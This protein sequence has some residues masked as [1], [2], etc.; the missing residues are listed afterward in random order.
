MA[1]YGK[2]EK[3]CATCIYWKGKRFVEFGFIETR[4]CEGKCGCDEGFYN[5]K[6]TDASCCSDWDGFA[7]EKNKLL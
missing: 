5:I 4:E 7:G 2:N 6:T 3:I 1:T